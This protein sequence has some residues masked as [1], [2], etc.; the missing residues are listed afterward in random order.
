MRFLSFQ[1]VARN[2][3]NDSTRNTR[4]RRIA[5]GLT[6]PVLAKKSIYVTNWGVWM[7]RYAQHDKARIVDASLRSA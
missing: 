7:L 6:F 4:I 1:A 3:Y 5:H 2:P